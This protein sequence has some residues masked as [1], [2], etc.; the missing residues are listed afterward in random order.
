MQ[1]TP[2]S[3]FL[4]IDGVAMTPDVGD[5][6][7]TSRPWKKGDERYFLMN[8]S[9]VTQGIV[10]TYRMYIPNAH[11]ICTYRMYIL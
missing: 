10:Y 11:I 9:S 8:P 7:W 4:N 5:G 2:S 3:R 6:L 1:V